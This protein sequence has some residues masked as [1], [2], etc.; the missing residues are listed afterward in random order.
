[1]EGSLKQRAHKG[2]IDDIV[3]KEGGWARGNKS[4]ENFFGFKSAAFPV[5]FQSKST[6]TKQ[7][8]DESIYFNTGMKK[9]K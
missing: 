7:N 8:D 1:M 6:K 9:I 2:S 3:E 5:Q 4:M